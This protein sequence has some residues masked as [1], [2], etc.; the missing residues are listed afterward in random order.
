MRRFELNRDTAN[1]VRTVAVILAVTVIVVLIHRGTDWYLAMLLGFGVAAV[2]ATLA[3]L[4]DQSS[5]NLK[6]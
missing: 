4:I 6:L 1:A 3:F 5:R 2:I